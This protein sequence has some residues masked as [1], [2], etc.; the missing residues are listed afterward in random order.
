MP[1]TLIYIL[2]SQYLTRNGLIHHFREVYSSFTVHTVHYG[3]DLFILL[4]QSAPHL[5]II[6]PLIFS[7]A[8]YDEIKRIKE[9]I[10]D[11]TLLIYGDS[12]D[13]IL[14]EK[15]IGLGIS[16]IILK[17][18]DIDIVDEVIKAALAKRRYFS[19]DILATIVGKRKNISNVSSAESLTQSEIN[20][21]RY[22]AQGLT[23]K[24]IATQKSLSVHTIIAHR[25]NIFRKLNI[26]NTSELV[27]YAYRNG[28]VDN[29]EYHI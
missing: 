7:S 15:C 12:L 1:K 13:Q 19:D 29:T 21:I 11:T 26:N 27:S 3:E 18:D 6:D 8:I 5:F 28:L 16:N 14:L 9:L 25:K 20:V 22:V 17:T 2:D 24:E 10:P 4:K 23:N